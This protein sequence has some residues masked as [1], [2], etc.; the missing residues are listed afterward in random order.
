ME[1][2]ANG[3]A[4]IGWVRSLGYPTAAVPIKG[5]L[6][7][8]WGWY[9]AEGDFYAY[10]ETDPNGT[11][12][13]VERISFNPAKMVCEDW[14]GILF[15]YRT[16]LGLEGVTDLDDG[17]EP[18]EGLQAACDWMAQWA[19]D[20]RLFAD[21]S[22]W[23]R[24]F[25]LGT[26]GFALGLDGLREDGGADAGTR[27]TLHRYDAASTVPLSWT[28]E[29]CTEAAFCAAI[30]HKGRPY[31][32]WTA[33]TLDEEG[34][35]VIRTAHF[36]G[37][38]QRV[39]LDGF[40]SEVRTGIDGPLFVLA[41]PEIDNTY[42]DC[43]PFGVSVFDG[44]LGALKLA[45]GSFD[46]AWRDVFLGQKLLFLPEEMLQAAPDGTVVVPRARDQQLFMA[47]PGESVGGE[48]RK[49]YEYNPSLRVEDNRKAVDT[50]LALLGKRCGFGMRYYS[51]DE[52]GN[53]KTAKEV[54]A[55]NAELMRNAKK[56]EQAMGAQV[57]RLA[58]KAVALA[59]RF[60]A[61]GLPDVSGKACVLFGDTII[62]D[63]DTE[64]ERMRADVAAG[65]VPAWKYTQTYYGVS[66]ETAKEW[67]GEGAS[68][69]AV[70]QGAVQEIAG[71]TL[72][73]AQTQALLGV[74]A[75]YQRG[76]LTE[77]QAVNVI[78]TAIGVTK[79]EAAK[80]LHGDVTE[81]MP[82]PA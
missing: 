67:T 29:G 38:G 65:L 2:S 59:N 68:G 49:P 37:N 40:A 79:E 11:T 28:S 81:A 18:E 70:D 22:S 24:A 61:A 71:K 63:E 62:Q 35:C 80:L 13:K 19:K 48:P 32:Q 36:K 14:A 54:G 23:E 16:S 33:Y 26:E 74:I 53:P 5:R 56:H 46:N 17:E 8:W 9:R 34:R 30:M 47:L 55:D 66:A 39:E 15:N 41:S 51:L 73:G 52:A 50:A 58:E 76:E 1:N 72:N 43:G 60:C 4:G 78:A 3:Y 44:A 69:G 31:T 12:F 7:E 25:G 57:S 6:D 42:R 27:V 75:Q 82:E 77:G 45:D 20:V 21:A 64:R 10:A